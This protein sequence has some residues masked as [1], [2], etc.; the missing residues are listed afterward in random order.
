LAKAELRLACPLRIV[1]GMAAR[2][3]RDEH[4]REMI[5]Q[6]LFTMPGERVMHPDFGVGVE[7]LVFETEGIEITSAA[8]SL[9][10]SSLQRWLGDV[11]AVHEV[12]VAAEQSTITVDVAYELVETR[13]LR[14]ERFTR[15]WGSSVSRASGGRETRSSSG[16]R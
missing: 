5:E 11:I 3:S 12:S 7:R 2:S 10:A 13:E 8:Q 15:V 14:K 6:V 16:S 9:I 1:H 4:I